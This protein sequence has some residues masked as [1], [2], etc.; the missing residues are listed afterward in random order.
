VLFF[1]VSRIVCALKAWVLFLN[2][3]GFSRGY[4]I[5]VHLAV[6]S[7]NKLFW[8]WRFASVKAVH[9]ESPIK[10]SLATLAKSAS[11]LA[12][13]IVTWMTRAKHKALSLAGLQNFKK[14][15]AAVQ[16]FRIVR[17]GGICRAYYFLAQFRIW[18]CFESFDHGASTDFTTV[19]AL[20]DDLFPALIDFF[21]KSVRKKK[22]TQ[23]RNS[24]SFGDSGKTTTGW[25]NSKMRKWSKI[26]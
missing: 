7:G 14:A 21:P 11:S 1:F 19:G 15:T 24:V 13:F 23:L 12:S 20:D 18:V 10:S 26:I 5:L 8:E 6:I 2:S 9:P 17:V 4:G 3:S 22:M 25:R 16:W